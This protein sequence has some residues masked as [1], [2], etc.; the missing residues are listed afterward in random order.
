MDIKH[1]RISLGDYSSMMVKVFEYQDRKQEL[2]ERW[3]AQW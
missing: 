1:E 3:Q 2:A